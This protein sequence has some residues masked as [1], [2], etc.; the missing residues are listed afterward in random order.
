MSGSAWALNWDFKPSAVYLQSQL[1]DSNLW[2]VPEIYHQSGYESKRSPHNNPAIVS[3]FDEGRKNNSINLRTI[4]IH[5]FPLL[6]GYNGAILSAAGVG[7]WVGVSRGDEQ[8]DGSPPVPPPAAS[9]P[10]RV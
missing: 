9:Q 5:R 3:T 2:N 8:T 6:P 4:T 1:M 10:T 7:G